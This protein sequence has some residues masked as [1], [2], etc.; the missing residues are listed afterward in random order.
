MAMSR[1]SKVL[2]IL[3]ALIVILAA[4]VAAVITISERNLLATAAVVIEEFDLSTVPDGVFIGS[5]N[6]FPVT[7]EV[8]VTVKNHQITAIALLKHGNGKGQAAEVIPQQVVDA[9]SLTVD[10]ISGAT[11]SSKVILLAI[12][13][14]LQN[15]AG[16]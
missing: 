3:V 10:T 14:A 13:N 2:L 9:Q 12:Q 11:Y 15:A 8:E 1:K 16:E 7:A 5:H 4:A 6:A